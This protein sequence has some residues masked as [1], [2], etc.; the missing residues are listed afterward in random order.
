MNAPADLPRI[1]R[2]AAAAGCGPLQLR[3]KFG[4]TRDIVRLAAEVQQ[5]IR[6]DVPF[7]INDRLDICQAVGAGGIHLGQ[8]DLPLPIARKLLGSEGIIGASCQT[9]EQARRAVAEGADYIGFGSVFK[10]LT[11]PERNPM[12]LELLA[13]VVEKIDIP[14]YAIGGIDAENLETLLNIGV[15]HF[16]VCRAISQ[17][18]DIGQAVKVLLQTIDSFEKVKCP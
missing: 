4:Y 18:D 12:D 13:K 3:Q 14:V 10:T 7:V 2:E 8:N 5:K 17:A 9:Y 11:K 15:T 6:P 16:A 1:A